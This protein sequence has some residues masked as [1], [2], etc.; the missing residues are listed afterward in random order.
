MVPWSKKINK[1]IGHKLLWSEAYPIYV[2]IYLGASHMEYAFCRYRTGSTKARCRYPAVVCPLPQESIYPSCP[3]HMTYIYLFAFFSQAV[4][5]NGDV[6]TQIIFSS[7]YIQTYI[8]TIALYY[9]YFLVIL[10][11]Q[12]ERIFLLIKLKRSHQK[13]AE[14]NKENWW[15]VLLRCFWG[16]VSAIAR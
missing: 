11:R 8:S 9:K 12:S 13:H 14:I 15:M 6:V 1:T 10:Q 4:Y 16:F 2:S 5:T 7:N 3:T